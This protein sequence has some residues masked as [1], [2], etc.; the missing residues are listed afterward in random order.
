MNRP[1]LLAVDATLAPVALLPATMDAAECATLLGCSKTT[2]E[3]PA[4]N[5]ELEATRFGRGWVFVTE[6]ILAHVK[7]RCEHEAGLRRAREEAARAG[8]ATYARHHDENR[9]ARRGRPRKAIPRLQ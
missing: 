7:A 1:F 2:I 3:E 9:V 5:G 4:A 6:Q 8:S